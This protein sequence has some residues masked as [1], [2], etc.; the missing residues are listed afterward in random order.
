MTPRHD[1]LPIASL[2]WLDF[3][4][5]TS[6]NSKAQILEIGGVITDRELRYLGDPFSC[7]VRPPYFHADSMPKPVFEMHRQSGL[8]DDVQSSV[9][10]N[11]AAEKLCNEWIEN[12]AA[13]VKLVHCGY[14]LQLDREVVARVMPQLYSRLGYRQLDLRS[15]EEA[16]DAWTFSGRFSRPK[17]RSHR[18]L[19][20]VFDAIELARA[21]RSAFFG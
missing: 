17:N 19:Q 11:E 3:E 7:V 13:D 20:D 10:S 18:A 15:L 8:L 14:Y 1:P 16:A 9:L 5:D 2:V 21:Y 12:I 4:F 6:D